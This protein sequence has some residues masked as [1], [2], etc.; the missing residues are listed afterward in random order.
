MKLTERQQ[1]VLEC[2]RK[3]M[4]YQVA[5]THLGLNKNEIYIDTLKLLKGGLITKVS[6]GQYAVTDNPVP[7]ET[8]PARR[9]RSAKIIDIRPPEPP[10][11]VKQKDAEEIGT[12]LLG[13]I[14]MLQP[15]LLLHKDLFHEIE[16]IT[17]ELVQVIVDQKPFVLTSAQMEEY[18]DLLQVKA[19]ALLLAARA[20]GM[21]K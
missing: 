7:I 10:P 14:G 18:K 17:M 20:R 4:R 2:I 13:K 5:A 1:K 21:K 19:R 12:E 16:T 15:V 6:K 3:G 8:A 9:G 11:P